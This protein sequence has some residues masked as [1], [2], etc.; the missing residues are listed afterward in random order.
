MTSL[1]F[2]A[3]YT[4]AKAVDDLRSIAASAMAGARRIVMSYSTP[5]APAPSRRYRAAGAREAL[6]AALGMV[7]VVGPLWGATCGAYVWMGNRTVGARMIATAGAQL[8]AGVAATHLLH[9][10]TTAAFVALA[11]TGILATP[12]FIKGTV[13]QFKGPPTT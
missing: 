2:R 9:S 3:G 4:T 11:A 8:L 1:A 7:P 12:G 6:A 5:D 13:K 10:P